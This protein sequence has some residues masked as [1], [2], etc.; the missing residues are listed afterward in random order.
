[1]LDAVVV[2]LTGNNKPCTGLCRSA[3]CLKIHFA[4]SSGIYLPYSA[5]TYCKAIVLQ[6]TDI[7]PEVH[8]V[9]NLGTGSYR[10]GLK[11]GTCVLVT[12]AKEQAVL[13]VIICHNKDIFLGRTVLTHVVG[14]IQRNTVP[15]A[16]RRSI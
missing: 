6:V 12:F 10:L 2:P 4:V 11:V 15:A 1:M 9:C 16:F 3:S 14:G 5:L 7:C 8:G 13:A